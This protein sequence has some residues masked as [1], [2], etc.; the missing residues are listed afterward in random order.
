MLC[1]LN[2]SF[3]LGGLAV[4]MLLDDA[5]WTNWSLSRLGETNSRT[6]CLHFRSTGV[7]LSGRIM[8]TIGFYESWLFQ[9]WSNCLAW[10]YLAG[11]FHC[12]RFV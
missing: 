11:Y 7:F 12:L 1:I 3:W 10:E 4:A 5:R 2:M 9:T 6:V 8:A